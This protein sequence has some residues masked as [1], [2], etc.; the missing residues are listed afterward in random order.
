MTL[1]KE[2]AGSNKRGNGKDMGGWERALA[3]S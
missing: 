1:G 3:A 2:R